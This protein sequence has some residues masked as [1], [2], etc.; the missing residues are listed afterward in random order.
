MLSAR[1]LF[2]SIALLMGSTPQVVWASDDLSGTYC[3]AVV[4]Y[5]PARVIARDIWVAWEDV[6]TF[7]VERTAQPDVY[8]VDFWYGASQSMH[9]CYADGIAERQD[10]GNLAAEFH[11]DM[12]EHICKANI[13]VDVDALSLGVFYNPECLSLCGYRAQFGG[14]VVRRVT[15]QVDKYGRDLCSILAR[16]EKQLQTNSLGLIE[17]GPTPP[18][19]IR[20]VLGLSADENVQRQMKPKTR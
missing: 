14:Q 19:N 16:S 17:L 8:R 6:T 9:Q 13:S 10:N 2:V 4:N 1:N 15:T 12:P 7:F 20:E 5:G 11:W 18:P 3:Q